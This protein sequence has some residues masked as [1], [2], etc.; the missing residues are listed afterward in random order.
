MLH[1]LLTEMAIHIASYLPLQSL[2]QASL[3]S[4]EWHSLIADNEQTL[5][6]NAAIL[7]RF[8]LHADLE[9]ESS[10]QTSDK[11]RDW[12]Q[13]CLCR[14]RLEIEKGW[15][16]KAPSTTKELTATGEY[17]LRIKVDEN[18]GFVIT[19]HHSG[20]LYVTDINTD[21]V[22]WAET[23]HVPGYVHCE[24]DRGYIVFNR[25]NN[26]KEVWRLARRFQH[27]DIPDNSRPNG[28]M[29]TASHEAARR[30]PS[31]TGRGHFR[32]WALIQM[33]EHT[34]NFRL[35]YPTLILASKNNAYVWDVPTSRLVET[36]SNIQGGD[37]HGSLGCLNYVDVNDKY[38]FVCGSLQLRIFR[39]NG[40]G[41]VYKLTK[42]MLPR[43][44]WDVLQESNNVACLSSLF[45]PQ[46][47]HEALH[48]SKSKSS[49]SSFKAAHVSSS[50]KDLVALTASG[51]FIWIPGFERLINREATLSEIA[52]VLNFS[53]FPDN[54]QDIS[55]YLAL[56]ELNE[57]AAIATR[58]GIYII[59]LDPEISKC[60]AEAPSRPGASVCRVMKYDN[61]LYLS[62]ITCLQMS[63]TGIFF[64]W[65]PFLEQSRLSRFHIPRPDWFTSNP[66]MT[67]QT[68]Y[69]NAAILHR[70]V[71]HADLERESSCHMPDKKQIDWT[72]FCRR[73]LEIERGWRGKGRSTAKE[74]TAAGK[75]VVQMIV[76]EHE[77]FV[78]TTSYN[79]GLY[80][81]DI[82]TDRVLW[83]DASHVP[84]YVL[85]AYDHGYLVR[86]RHNNSAL[87]EVWR[88]ARDFQDADIP[89][90]S[91]K[92]DDY[93][94]AAS[95]EAARCYP[96]ST[97][98]G[99]FRPWALLRLPEGN[100]VF[101][102]SYPTLIAVTQNNAYL[103]DVPTSRRVQT[104]V[105]I[106]ARNQDGP[107]GEFN[108][109]DVN[110]KY[111]FLCGFHQLRIFARDG[112]ALVYHLTTKMLPRT[113]WD[114]LPASSN[115]ACSSSLFQPQ[116]LHAK[117]HA[118]R[119]VLKAVRVSSSGNDMVVIT[120]SGNIVWILGFERLIH[121][122]ASLR[123]TAIILNFNP[124]SDYSRDMSIYLALGGSNEKAAI[125]T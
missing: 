78:I 105:N 12:K 64:N 27:S 3:V 8:V 19:T 11:K 121:G 88:L 117:V 51:N 91:K 77:G 22:L 63:D 125:A 16:G 79:G 102:I 119:S 20:G 47:L 103:W 109:V 95:H 80:V 41:L 96:S 85:W 36:I 49:A 90:N 97:G 38:A 84:G 48:R 52:V 110:D 39:R 123:E 116:Q 53:P 15:R 6:R 5:Y 2:Y 56:G 37:Q 89:D 10:S 29:I 61:S 66:S 46:Q 107:P 99:H 86:N 87:K 118:H 83:A 60:T 111:V 81:T 67:R 55:I 75:F 112:G 21:R 4:R 43:T 114:V 94:I 71:L 93:M 69:R 32:P 73:Q 26:S 24:Y 7:H 122:K 57:K 9:A 14:R 13:L 106:Q 59:N 1:L 100:W 124:F 42:K 62:L 31:S 92:P 35:S 98:H 72:Q 108:S 76:D 58:K 115:V 50:G 17:V 45:Q 68:L 18:E 23:T 28:S 25:H 74:L 70:F 104:I 54:S 82:N 40:G 101:H 65:H 33:P 44:Q 34:S 120:V 30:Y 113:R